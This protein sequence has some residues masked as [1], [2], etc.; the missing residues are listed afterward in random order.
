MKKRQIVSAVSRWVSIPFLTG[1]SFTLKLPVC[2]VDEWRGE[3]GQTA[4]GGTM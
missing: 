2:V 1:G 4:A 3:T